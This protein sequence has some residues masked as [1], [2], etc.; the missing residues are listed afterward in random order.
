M[1]VL[2]ASMLICGGLAAQEND[3]DLSSQR[4]ES[5]EVNRVPG[6]AM[7]HHGLIINPTPHSLQRIE[8]KV[9]DIS[10]G[11]R[12]KG[13]QS[14]MAGEM[15]FLTIGKKGADLRIDFGTVQAKKRE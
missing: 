3:F 4:S 14:G 11:F 8:G 1:P 10:R 12:L 15:D 13:K 2:L 9:L 6:Q 7:D 5:Q